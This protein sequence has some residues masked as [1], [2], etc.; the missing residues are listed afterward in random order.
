MSSICPA[1][2][3]D[4]SGAD[5]GYRPN[6]RA[7]QERLVDAF[8][9]SCLARDLEANAL[10]QVDCVV[11]EARAGNTCD[12]DA[13]GREPAAGAEA[14]LSDRRRTIRFVGEGAPSPGSALFLDCASGA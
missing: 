3:G 11:V 9:A 1:H 13:P 14:L 4:E 6:V 10:D 7:L 5:F 12:C 8:G 2:R